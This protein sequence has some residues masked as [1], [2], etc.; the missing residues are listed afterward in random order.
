MNVT[1]DQCLNCP[2]DDCIEDCPFMKRDK[3]TVKINKPRKRRKN[4]YY[5]KNKEKIL[6]Y[7]KEWVKNNKEKVREH[8][9]KYRETHKDKIIESRRKYYLSHKKEILE[10]H[11]EYFEK[12]RDILLQKMRDNYAKKEKP[13]RNKWKN[14]YDEYNI[15]FN[16]YL[17]GLKSDSKIITT[18]N[19]F[20]NSLNHLFQKHNVSV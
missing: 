7:N 17:K 2:Y 16:G 6:A 18:A 20:K 14:L 4:N 19:K 13:E 12:Y 5:L 9:K 3:E 10:K 8:R 1:I 15:I 11:K